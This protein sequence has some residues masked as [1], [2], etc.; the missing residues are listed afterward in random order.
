[1]LLYL[2]MNFA[3]C[4]IQP[5]S[6]L[7][8]VWRSA[9]RGLPDGKISLESKPVYKTD[10]FVSYGELCVFFYMGINQKIKKRKLNNTLRLRLQPVTLAA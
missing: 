9:G 8:F 6:P 7:G 2:H 4:L 1:M 5:L 3:L 10:P